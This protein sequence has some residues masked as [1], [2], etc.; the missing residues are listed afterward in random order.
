MCLTL[1]LAARR[2]CKFFSLGERL[3]SVRAARFASIMGVISAD[4][5]LNQS[6]DFEVFFPNVAKAVRCMVSRKVV[7]F[8]VAESP[9]CEI[10]KINF[11]ESESVQL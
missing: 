1:F 6:Y 11:T 10:P 3:Y 2:I 8:A 7:H 9:D 4:L 5:A